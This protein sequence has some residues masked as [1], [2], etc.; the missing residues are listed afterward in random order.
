[1]QYLVCSVF[2]K[3]TGNYSRPE[4]QVN[5]EEAIRAFES[6][7]RMSI[8]QKQGLLFTHKDDYELWIIDSFDSEI[9]AFSSKNIDE[10]NNVKRE[11]LI[12][13]SDIRE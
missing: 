6:S 12:R 8:A 1:M 11:M 4:L 7:I 5:K 2:D 10:F 3:V 13:G 9:G